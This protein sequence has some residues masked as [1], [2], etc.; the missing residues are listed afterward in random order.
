MLFIQNNVWK[1]LFPH[2]TLFAKQ[3]DKK[4]YLTGDSI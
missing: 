1:F 3:M 2:T 4:L